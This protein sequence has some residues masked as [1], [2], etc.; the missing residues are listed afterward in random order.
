M[1]DMNSFAFRAEI[2]EVKSRKSS[3]LDISYKVILS[4]DDA[5]VLSL[6]AL[7]GDQ[8]L[9]VTVETAN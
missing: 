7:D 1:A 4:T 2:K 5:R 9:R 3:S 8:L 6:G